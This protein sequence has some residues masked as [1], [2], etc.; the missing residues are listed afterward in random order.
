MFLVLI[1]PYMML[2]MFFAMVVVTV[3]ELVPE[4]PAVMDYKKLNVPLW[5]TFLA[6]V[7]TWPVPVGM[8]IWEKITGEK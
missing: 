4:H 7:I 3:V 2:G 6:M 8:I 1:K 5:K